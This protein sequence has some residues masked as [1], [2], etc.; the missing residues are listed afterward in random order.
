MTERAR[1]RAWTLY[2]SGRDYNNRLTPNQ[3][4]LVET[5]TEFF[6]GNQWLNLP[7]TPAMRSLPKP[8]FNILK[9]V[10]SLFIASL[11][12]SAVRIRAEPLELSGNAD[13]AAFADAEI[14]NLLEKF[15]FDY[16][17]RDALFDGAQ[18]GDYCAHFWFDPEARPYRGNGAFRDYRG[19]IRMEL[20]DGINVMF[21][22]PHD[23]AVERQ[24]WVLL[25]GRDSV[26]NLTREARRYR[27]DASEI[28]PD[29]E[30]WN[31][32]GVGGKTELS[33]D[34]K[35]LYV[36][37][38]EKAVNKRGETT[39]HVTKA[40]RD[41]AIYENIDTGL[42]V[43]P[44]AWGNWE[45]Q[46]NQYHGRALVTGLIPNQIF[47]NTLFATAMRH[48]QLMAFPRAVYNADLISAWTNEVGQAIAVR[49]LQPG[50]SVES[51]AGSISAPEMSAQIFTLIDKAMNYTKECLGVSDVQLGNARP[52]N[53]SALALLQTNAEVPL[54]NVRAGL[55]EWAENVGRV[56][57]DM[58]G[59]C[60]GSRPVVI[61][62]DGKTAVEDFDFRVFKNLW[63]N[64]RIEA[65]E[66]TRFSEISVKDT[67]DE[68]RR[69]GF[70]TAIQY[71]ERV[72]DR[73]FPRKAEL[74]D[75][76]RQQSPAAVTA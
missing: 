21:G 29:A 48:I 18:T 26:R 47:I 5:N 61:R 33:G 19:E 75:E 31:F 6:I 66:T 20:V 52:E 4:S 69:D 10:A 7:N 30:T 51:V 53:T 13:A 32:P 67:L 73:L 58:M 9:R 38:Y 11:T 64:L 36:L 71:L 27:A 35:A 39:V 62:R 74:L 28:R 16:R 57:L 2:E 15:H 37:L 68:L 44:I 56:L 49:G 14:A 8:T 46:R 70:L 76:L 23:R 24:P 12:A 59:T 60:Y 41:A 63:L 22:A 17:V 3:Y 55:Y 45:K 54:E 42:S 34:E 43:Y 40:T 50:Q 25:V 65:G 1:S 72:P